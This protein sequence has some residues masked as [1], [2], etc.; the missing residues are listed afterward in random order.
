MK[1]LALP[2]TLLLSALAVAA[3][4]DR[5][6]AQEAP[7]RITDRAGRTV[8]VTSA[9]ERI[10]SLYGAHTENLFALGA[11]TALIGV[12]RHDHYPPEV[13]RKPVFS[14]HD[15]LERFLAAGPDL[16]LIRPMID[17]GYAPLV[18]GLE[19]NGITVV[20]LQPAAVDDMYAY[21]RPASNP[22]A[23]Q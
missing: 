8:T 21:W 20:S 6:L 10:I 2:I 22:S 23:R 7:P 3:G 12:S 14:Y 1:T 17:R 5:T 4:E 19:K 9:F 18:E 15:G 13:R 11:N 16:V